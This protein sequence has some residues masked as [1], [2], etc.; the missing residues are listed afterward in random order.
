MKLV[1]LFTKKKRISL[2]FLNN[3]IFI[4]YEKEKDFKN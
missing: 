4:G 2:S 3:E 1:F